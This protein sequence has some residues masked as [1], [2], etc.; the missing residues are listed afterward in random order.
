LF[1]FIDSRGMQV[2]TASSVEL[3]HLA[4]VH[5]RSRGGE[6][7]QPVAQPPGRDLRAF[8]GAKQ[9]T[10]RREIDSA[11][12]RLALPTGAST[13]IAASAGCRSGPSLLQDEDRASVL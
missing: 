5:W 4:A 8:C 13:S 10:Q 11:G 7:D 1:T 9:F 6:R 3:G 12:R 2:G